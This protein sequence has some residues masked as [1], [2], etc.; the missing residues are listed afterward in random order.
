MDYISLT[1]H[2]LYYSIAWLCSFNYNLITFE[3]Q[4]QFQKSMDYIIIL[5]DF[6]VYTV[7]IAVYICYYC[8]LRHKYPTGKGTNGKAQCAII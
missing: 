4:I 6:M 7:S 5:P 3:R 8:P 1:V 2:V